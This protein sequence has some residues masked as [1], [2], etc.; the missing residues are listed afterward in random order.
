MSAAHLPLLIASAL[1]LGACAAAP[2]TPAPPLARVA[3]KGAADFSDLAI[4]SGVSTTRAECEAVSEAVWVESAAFGSECLRYWKAG[5]GAAPTP[6]AV[7]YFHGD[8]WLGTETSPSYLKLSERSLRAATQE[9]SAKLGAPY[10]HFARPGTHGSSGDHMQRRRRGES[11]LITLALD[12]LKTRYGISEWV[13]VGQSG[14]GHVTASLLVHRNDIVCAV[15]TSSVSSPRM[16]WTLRGRS[17]DTTGYDDSY[18]PTEFIAGK[19]RH[20]KLRIFV[21]GSVEDRNTPWAIQTLL[22]SRARAA[23]L[24]VMELTGEGSGPQK[25]GMSNSGRLVAGWCARDL[26]DD[27]IREKASAGLKG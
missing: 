26:S 2:A 12:R 22:T 8:I 19:D 14:G 24:P 3:L 18:E 15:P 17:T 6:R 27:E 1:L 20:P 10:I 16:R 21:V 25:H 13:V 23:G 5:F 7:V 4:R 11:E 9:W